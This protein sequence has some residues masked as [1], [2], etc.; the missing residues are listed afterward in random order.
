MQISAGADANNNDQIYFTDGANKLYR[1]KLAQTTGTAA[2]AKNFAA[3]SGF[4]A[5]TDGNNK[6]WTSDDTGAFSQTVSGAAG[7]RAVD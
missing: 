1:Y 4:V 7:Q 5:F 6:V 3:G 2:F